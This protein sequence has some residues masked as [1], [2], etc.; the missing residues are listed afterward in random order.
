M[1]KTTPNI[2]N[3]TYYFYTITKKKKHSFEVFCDVFNI[4][5]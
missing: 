3:K 2:K 1:K 5:F 4:E